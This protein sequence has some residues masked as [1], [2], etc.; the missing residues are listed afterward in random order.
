[1]QTPDSR[2][3]IRQA[4]REDLGKAGDISTIALFGKHEHSVFKLL[5]KD[6][7]C[8]CGMDVFCQVFNMVDRRLQVERLYKDG[9]YIESGTTVARVSGPS[10]SILTGERTALNFISHLSGI[11]SKTATFVAALAA[12]GE[13]HSRATGKQLTVPIVLDTRKTIPGLRLLQKYAVAC[14]GGQN[15]R[16]GLY[17]MVMLKDN[18][19]DA[20]GGIPNAVAKAR[21]RWG[22]RYKIEVETRNLA[23]VQQALTAGADRIMLDNMDD[24][25]MRQAV[26]L[27]A[28]R[29]ET[30]ASGNMTLERLCALADS[31]ISYVSFGE[32]THSVRVFDFSLKQERNL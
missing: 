16:I 8:L 13:Q 18:H 31:G 29:A 30:E 19:I 15:H 17:D 12:A 1:M 4:L 6:S 23:E 26:Q 3:L 10:A 14:G 20:A 28:G 27:V 22:Q 11:A 9:D 5:A 21:T 32:L 24:A 2:K 7:G 25:T